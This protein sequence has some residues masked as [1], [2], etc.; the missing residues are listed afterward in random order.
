VL[1]DVIQKMDGT[2]HTINPAMG[3][4]G[5][6]QRF[7]ISLRQMAAI[8]ENEVRKPG[9]KLLIWVGPGWPMLDSRSFTMS[10][11]Q[12]STYFDTIVNLS[13][14]LREAHIA[15]YSVSAPWPGMGGA[16]DRQF[17]YQ[18]FLKGVYSLR[19]ADTGNLA[20]KVLAVQ[21]G[22][23][24]LGP[25][26]ELAGQI[27]NCVADASTFYTVSFNPPPAEHPNEYHDL[28]LVIDKSGPS[29]RTSTRYYNQP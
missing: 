18:D 15:V 13:T 10:P 8:A 5:D 17:L 21:S 24:I 19:E 16:A 25:D 9:R 20:L 12:Q 3:A 6:L 23:R 2:V 22:G 28:K 1:A 11:R 14:W 29:V 27:A 26:N 7:Q 4:A